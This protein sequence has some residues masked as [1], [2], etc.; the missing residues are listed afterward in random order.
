MRLL[1][2]NLS[3]EDFGPQKALEYPLL[4][5]GEEISL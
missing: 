3:D 1:A 4:G 5:I 2:K